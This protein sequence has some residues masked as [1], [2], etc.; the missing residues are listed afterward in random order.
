MKTNATTFPA[1]QIP[2]DGSIEPA[3]TNSIS[4]E[5]FDDF[6]PVPDLKL[7]ITNRLVFAL[8]AQ[9]LNSVPRLVDFVNLDRMTGGMDIMRELV[10]RTN[11]FGDA[12]LHP[13]SFWITNR[14]VAKLTSMTWGI[15][16]QIVVSTNDALARGDWSSYS[17]D[18]TAGL[19]RPKAVDNF[20]KLLGLPP[21]F[22][23]SNTNVPY[24]TVQVPF[25]PT[26][27]LDQ[28]LSWQAND[29]LVHYHIEDLSDGRL[30][31]VTNLQVLTPKQRLD[32]SNIGQINDP[33]YRP[34]GGNPK[35]LPGGPKDYDLAVKDPLLAK[36]DDWEFRT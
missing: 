9:D 26:R 33:R 6:F 18:P 34:W 20:R 23:T 3:G 19:D 11:A 17:D 32:D 15:T 36:S 28:K 5:R 30:T 21:I 2:S 4:F 10:G 29:P 14:A 25:T 22:D 16:N 31:S 1:A 27:K 24:G 35:N 8:V 7:Y 12:G 13:G